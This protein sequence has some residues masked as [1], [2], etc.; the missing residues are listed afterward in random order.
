MANRGALV[1]HMR[2][3]MNKKFELLQLTSCVLLF[4]WELA[5]EWS[6]IHRAA[7]ATLAILILAMQ[8]ASLR[9]IPWRTRPGR[10]D[11]R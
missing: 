3:Q 10:I 5:D 8:I 6:S 11:K 1:A 7:A 4:A 9:F 2:T